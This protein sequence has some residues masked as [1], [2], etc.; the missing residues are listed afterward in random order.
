MCHV[1]SC[2]NK[3][4]IIMTPF[5]RILIQM[6]HY[7]IP[8]Q[9]LIGPLFLHKKFF[10]FLWDLFFQKKK[11]LKI[12]FTHVTCNSLWPGST[13]MLHAYITWIKLNHVVTKQCYSTM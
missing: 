2:A 6:G 10:F 3:D 13:I 7:V 9:D 1:L 5:L 4:I 8:H 12:I 11:T